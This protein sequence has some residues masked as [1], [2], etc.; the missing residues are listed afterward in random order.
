M[1]PFLG[2]AKG[3]ML[4]MCKNPQERQQGTGEK[5]EIPADFF[6]QVCAK[7]G[8]KIEKVDAGLSLALDVLHLFQEEYERNNLKGNPMHGWGPVLSIALEFIYNKQ[9][10]LEAAEVFYKKTLIP[11][12]KPFHGHK[13]VLNLSGGISQ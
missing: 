2:K 1:A 9:E 3:R 7:L 4:K 8:Y 12:L 11:V 10:E 5:I 13:I 6:D